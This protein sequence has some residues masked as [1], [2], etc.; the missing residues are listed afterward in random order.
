MEKTVEQAVGLRSALVG[1]VAIDDT[2]QAVGVG[3]LMLQ[4]SFYAAEVA[5]Y[6]DVGADVDVV[7]VGG[8]GD[9]NGWMLVIPF[10]PLGHAVF[11]VGA[12]GEEHAG[13]VETVARGE[14]Q[15][16]GKYEKV[17]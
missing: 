7:L 3:I 6:V 17:S 15:R 5:F 9:D 13:Y 8:V 16:G 4:E 14:C 10:E 2:E 12:A 11:G 1:E